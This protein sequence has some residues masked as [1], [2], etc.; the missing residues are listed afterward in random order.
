MKM[1]YEEFRDLIIEM[2]DGNYVPDC[3]G[4]TPISV[5]ELDNDIREL[6]VQ[7]TKDSYLRRIAEGVE[8]IA[9]NTNYI[10]IAK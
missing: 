3:E 10:K 5:T 7:I 4:I 1:D 6:F 9:E 8:K 2:I